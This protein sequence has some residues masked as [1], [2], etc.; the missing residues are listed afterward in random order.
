MKIR[1]GFVS[2]SSSSSFIIKGFI[3]PNDVFK[4]LDFEELY[5]KYGFDK[6]KYNPEYYDKDEVN[7][8]FLRYLDGKGIY[9]SNDF[10]SIPRGSSIIGVKIFKVN[11]DYGIDMPSLILDTSTTPLL[12]QIRQD[13]G[14]Q[15]ADIKIICGTEE[16]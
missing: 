5:T 8:E 15:N 13:F 9:Y 11:F 12:E 3:L 10:Y 2:N 7:Y 1:N 4:D 14:L 6:T 16:C